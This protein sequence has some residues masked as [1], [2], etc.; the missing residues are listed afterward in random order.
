MRKRVD[1]PH[2]PNESGK[3]LL[4]LSSSATVMVDDAIPTEQTIAQ[5]AQLEVL[6]VN[7]DKVKF[8]SVFESKKAIVVFIRTLASL[9]QTLTSDSSA[10]HFFCGVSIL[11]KRWKTCP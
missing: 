9:H 8:G 4:F 11:Q 1:A 6:D 3:M 10:G 2:T 5:A 7:G